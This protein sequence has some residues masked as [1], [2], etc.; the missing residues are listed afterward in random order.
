MDKKNQYAKVGHSA[1]LPPDKI[2]FLQQA[3]RKFFLYARAV[4][5]TMMQALNDNVSSTDVK[6]TYNATVI[7]LDRGQTP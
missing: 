5:T 1:P 4:N 3:T 7:L 6:S 2:K